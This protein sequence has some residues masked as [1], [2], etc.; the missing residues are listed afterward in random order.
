MGFETFIAGRYLRSP[1]KD[2][3]ISVIT[4]ISILGVSLGVAALI[5]VLSVMNGFEKDLKG[6][7][8]GANPHIMI[9]SMV[10]SEIPEE[11]LDL[12]RK[13]FKDNDQ[14]K[15]IAPFTTSQAL[16]MGR[17]KPQGS[18]IRGIDPVQELKITRMER[19]VRTRLFDDKQQQDLT[20][21]EREDERQ[22]VKSILTS[23]SPHIEILQNKEGKQ[24][25]KRVSGIIIG[26]QLAKKL[27]VQVNQW[28]TVLSPEE[29]ITPMGN[30]PRAKK[31]KVVG[32]FESGL[33]GYDEILAYIDYKVAQKVF[34]M[35]NEVSGL[36]IALV[37]GSQ[38]NRVKEL[39]KGQIEFPYLITTWTDQ[40]KNLFAVI[41][42][43]K[44]GLAVI[45]TLIIVIASFNI[46]S[47]L[48]ML[49]IEK[50]KDIAIL[51]SL[52][53]SNRSIRKIFILQGSVIG[54]TGTIIGEIL[55]LLLC[56]IISSFDV[57]DIPPGVYAGN[58][59]PMHVEPWQLLLIAII[60][61]LICFLVTIMPSQKA[62][63]L[64]PVEG[65]KNE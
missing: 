22:N 24:I 56:W 30:M 65:L 13:P 2:R 39:M 38:A 60:S 36:S 20:D 6:A 5:I 15:G 55:G 32:F 44:L 35:Q 18:L 31:F 25:K 27:G 23:L 9:Q 52:G 54:L 63:N 7:L 12:L 42:L 19:Y 11:D 43:E 3:S 29:R 16:I 40:N 49:V 53:A 59:I 1:R 51:K 48:V 64:D 46:I 34:R 21:K 45:L 26:T 50:N 47:S 41:Q 58:R 10:S 28:V 57:I 33:M 8:E 61:F 62:S 14:V 17:D 37:D 4:K